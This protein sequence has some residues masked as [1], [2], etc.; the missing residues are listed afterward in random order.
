MRHKGTAPAFTLI[1][2]L[3][4]IAIIAVLAALLF[5]VFSSAKK[6]AKKTDC[7]SNSRQIGQAMMLYLS[8]SDDSYP[9]TRQTLTDPIIED[10]DGSKDQPIYESVFIPLLPYSGKVGGMTDSAIQPLFRC[11][12]DMDPFG[13]QCFALNPDSNDV[14]SYIENGTFTFGLNQS[15]VLHP[16]ELILVS[17]RRSNATADWNPFCDDIYHPWFNPGNPLAPDNDM[18]PLNGAIAANRHS[19]VSNFTFVDGHAKALHWGQTF[20]IGTVN[21]H[22]NR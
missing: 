18:D 20:S 7:L 19:G 4:V 11:P 22:E 2:L 8:D 9:Q 17:E 10:A 14:T 12:E 1:E 16:S 5:P 3:V 15:A 13:R 21:L 6:T